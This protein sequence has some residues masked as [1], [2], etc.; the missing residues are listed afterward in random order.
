MSDDARDPA[1]R[2]APSGRKAPP[3][4]P[5]RD[6]G[7]PTLPTGEPVLHRWFVIAMLVLVPIAL[8]VSIWAAT[9]TFGRAELTPAERRPPGGPE[10][11]IER[12]AAQLSPTDELEQGP[13]CFQGGQII[14]DSGSRAAAR[15]AMQGACDLIAGGGYDEALAGLR[16]WARTDGRVRIAAFELSGVESSARLEDGRLVIELNAAFQF[17][18]ATAAAPAVIHQLALLAAPDFPGAPIPGEQELRAAQLQRQA[19][20]EL[21]PRLRPRGCDDVEEL[22]AADDPL[23]DLLDAGWPR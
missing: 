8:G 6:D 12:G 16:K 23:Q 14:G 22:L 19:C 20:G 7:L 18:D 21:P 15:R 4:P 3:L 10:V 2:K 9:A 5:L 17:E 1:G 13:A 11:T